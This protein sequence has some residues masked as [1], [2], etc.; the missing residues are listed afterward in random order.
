[1]DKKQ[2]AGDSIVVGHG[3]IDGRTVFVF[4]MDFTKIGG[5]VSRVL[6]N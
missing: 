5:S 6:A 4:S 2:F 1:M 3:K